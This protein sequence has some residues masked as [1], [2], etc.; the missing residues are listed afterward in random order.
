MFTDL[1]RSRALYELIGDA[2]A[3][4]SVRDRFTVLTQTVRKHDGGVA[5]TIGG[6]FIAAFSIRGVAYCPRSTFRT[7]LLNSTDDLTKMLLR[8][9]P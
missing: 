8:A 4:D 7:W 9:M 5:K 2:H 6:G 1:H 3:Y